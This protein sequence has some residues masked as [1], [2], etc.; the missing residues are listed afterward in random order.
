MNLIKSSFLAAL[1][2]I[3]PTIM[4]AQDEIRLQQAYVYL[5]ENLDKLK[6]EESDIPNFTVNHSYSD[7]K[8]KATYIYLDQTYNGIP[9]KNAMMVMVINKN[10][11][12]V[13]TG[14]SCVPQLSK[15]EKINSYGKTPSQ[16]AVSA[17]VHLGIERPEEPLV[18]QRSNEGIL[19]LSKTNFVKSEIKARPVYEYDE[20]NNKIVLCYEFTMDM[21]E[22]SD[23]WEISIA[24]D[25]GNFIAK[26][27]LTVY[28]NHTHNKWQHQENCEVVQKTTKDYRPKSKFEE[29]VQNVPRYRV[30][31]FPTESPIHGPQIL[32]TD[33]SNKIASPE[34]WNMIDGRGINTTRGNNTNTFLDEDDNDTQDPG[35]AVIPTDSLNFDYPHD[36]SQNPELF[37]NAA[38]VNL[39]YATNMM[40]DISYLYGFTEEAGNFQTKNYSALGRG[41]DAVVSQAFDGFKAPTPK[42][43]NANFTSPIDGSSGRMQMFL[44]DRSTGAVKITSPNEIA[45]GISA[46]GTSTFGPPIPRSTDPPVLGQ[47]FVVR[48]PGIPMPTFACQP[49]TQNL[50][51]KIALIDR[52]ECNFIEK[53]DFAQKAGAI[54]CV[55]CNVAGI[56]GGNGEEIINIGSPTNINIQINIP[57]ISLRKSDCDRIRSVIAKGGDVEMLLQET[58]LTGPKYRDGSFDNGVIAHEYAHG[59]SNRLTGGPNNTSCLNNDEQMGE[60]WSDF[61]SLATS[62]KLGDN[63]TIKRGI[64]NFAINLT[65]DGDGIRRYPYSTDMNVNPQTYNSIKG[66]VDPHPVGEIWTDMLWDLYWAMADKYGFDPDITNINS[67]NGRAIQLVM[68]GMRIQACRPG[69]TEGRDAIIGA[70]L[71][72][73]NGENNCLIWEVFARRGLGYLAFGGSSNDRNDGIENFELLPTCI[74]KLKISKKVP[75]VV[76]AGSIIDIELKA[77][78]HIPAMV[79]NVF[80][81]DD[82][83]TGYEYIPG[84]ANKSASIQNGKLRI[85]LGDMQYEEE[86]TITYKLRVTTQKS[87]T[88]VLY[89]VDSGVDGFN[90][91]PSL[92][93][94][95]WR[96][97]G[98][99]AK[100]GSEA[101]FIPVTKESNDHSLITPSI[102]LPAQ[103]PIL[104]FYHKYNTRPFIDGGYVSVSK[105]N[106]I[107]WQNLDKEFIVNGPNETIDYSTF[108]IPS[109]KGFTGTSKGNYIDSYVDLSEF[110]GQDVLIRFRFGTE[111][112]TSFI[113]GGWWIDDIEIMDAQ[114]GVTIA[115]INDEVKDKEACTAE[116]I[117]LVNSSVG[118]TSVI[119]EKSNTFIIYPNP[120]SD[121]INLVMDA[122]TSGESIIKIY[123]YDGSIKMVYKPW[124]TNG[125]NVIPVDISPLQTGVYF[126]EVQNNNGT[127]IK[128][129]VKAQ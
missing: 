112:T 47:V 114:T 46:Y 19:T 95:T 69:F 98:E 67:G 121:L 123:S 106:G 73:F 62:V 43:N 97:V 76:E 104:K 6:L 37:K 84:S 85:V 82:I 65:A 78:N 36:I 93:F 115:C 3:L 60:G 120:A 55:I 72:L 63:G 42:L 15:V 17:A 126:I 45:R 79:K 4:I 35:S 54:A 8:T 2:L 128:K 27:N 124:L 48:Q 38:Q 25:N 89:N 32:V 86:A 57:T 71:L 81:D 29:L 13:H 20:V 103:K 51:G 11:K 44:W 110:K 50:T 33:P 90:I 109:L 70:D 40:H 24:Q 61:F 100:S 75:E 9:I 58:A 117:I 18:L 83:P 129:M 77:I 41:S 125:N 102:S 118:T 66:T 16:L 21:A 119:D 88:S 74:E 26:N 96:I 127:S 22:S 39:F 68:E 80:I 5:K 122:K 64:G 99:G 105:D 91:I 111:D 31:P 113:D 52:G 49:L 53:A 23:Y 28:C 34:G 10:G 116:R 7:D 107:T 14:N 87:T 30:Y 94:D 56:N 1:T 59:I 101:F 92:G 108:A 12:I